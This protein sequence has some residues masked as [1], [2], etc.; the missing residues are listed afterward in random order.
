MATAQVEINETQR[1]IDANTFVLNEPCIEFNGAQFKAQFFLDQ[2]NGISWKILSAEQ[3]T[4]PSSNCSMV[5]LGD[6]PNEVKYDLS[7]L[8]VADGNSDTG[9]RFDVKSTADATRLDLGFSIVKVDA[10]AA[11]S[12]VFASN[13]ELPLHFTNEKFGEGLDVCLSAVAT[14]SITIS[15]ANNSFDLTLSEETEPGTKKFCVNI[16][17]EKLETGD[18]VYNATLNGQI[19]VGS[20]VTYWNPQCGVQAGIC[21]TSQ[22]ISNFPNGFNV[23]IIVNI[24]SY[25]TSYIGFADIVDQMARIVDTVSLGWN[26]DV[27]RGVYSVRGGTFIV[28]PYLVDSFKR[29]LILS[30]IIVVSQ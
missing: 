13:L 21:G 22:N 17:Q 20:A 18:V 11:P 6:A 4:E 29:S 2:S 24:E 5:R 15:N 25:K 27:F 1:Y 10:S 12:L 3:L 7:Y 26:G 16:P 9:Q 23:P 14:D 30:R 28:Q 19:I 8:I